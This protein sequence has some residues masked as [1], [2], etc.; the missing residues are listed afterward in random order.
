MNPLTIQS[1]QMGISGSSKSD[2]RLSSH[3]ANP[4]VCLKP[5]SNCRRG[6]N[7]ATANDD[8]LTSILPRR[9]NPRQRHHVFCQQ[10][11]WGFLELCLDRANDPD[12]PGFPS[13]TSS[14]FIPK[15]EI[16]A[17]AGARE[18][19][20]KA[21]LEEQRKKVFGLVRAAATMETEYPGVEDLAVSRSTAE[22]GCGGADPPTAIS[23]PCV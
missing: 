8:L 22:N 4:G 15:E 16:R 10:G 17:G 5:R 1:Q 14:F 6:T 18:E 7:R 2:K 21:A 3:S 9:S 23:Y 13:P 11:Q 12:E 20:Y 19:K